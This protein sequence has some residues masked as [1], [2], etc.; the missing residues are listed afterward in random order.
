MDARP[1]CAVVGSVLPAELLSRAIADLGDIIELHESS[2]PDESDASFTSGSFYGAIDGGP[3]AN[4][5]EE[6]AR[7]IEANSAAL[8]A[9]LHGSKACGYEWWWQE[10][11]PDEAPKGF[12]TDKCAAL[13][14]AETAANSEARV[15]EAHPL[16]SSVLYLT[17]EGG[18]TAVF[19]QHLESGECGTL[20]R[21]AVPAQIIISA[22]S[23]NRLLLFDGRLLHGVL[24]RPNGPAA[25][26]RRTLLINWWEE[27]PPGVAGA[28][29][30]F[31]C[32]RPPAED[33]VS[34]E[35]GESERPAFPAVIQLGPVRFLADARE[36]WGAQRAPPEVDA[37]Y[38]LQL[39]AG[40]PPLQLVRY[41]CNELTTPDCMPHAQEAVLRSRRRSGDCGAVASA[42]AESDLLAVWP[43]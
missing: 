38:A 30:S 21:P 23:S 26:L 15:V 40:R 10:H 36:H 4:A 13:Q 22:P 43:P 27:R 2:P 35:S 3:S 8:R 32:A 14:P 7:Y 29:P 33:G 1:F 5:V 42:G 25:G 28:P 6:A 18:P 19:D 34:A 41:A 31:A 16:V 24:H 12:H 39:R 37:D 9:M 17:D 20:A 11:E